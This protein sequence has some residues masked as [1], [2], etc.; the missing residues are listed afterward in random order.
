MDYLSINADLVTGPKQ[1]TQTTVTVIGHG[2]EDGEL[3]IPL[4]RFWLI[5]TATA[6]WN[7]NERR[8]DDYESFACAAQPLA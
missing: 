3:V 8:S 7:T 6:R 5:S 1:R 4:A 2:L